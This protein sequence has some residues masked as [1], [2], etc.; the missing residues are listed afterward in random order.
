MAIAQP[1]KP[2]HHKAGHATDH[3]HPH[4]HPHPRHTGKK[5][6]RRRIILAVSLAAIGGFGLWLVNGS[7][8]DTLTPEQQLVEQMHLAASGGAVASAHSLGGRLSVVHSQNG[9]VVQADGLE[10][11]AC[12]SVGWR[13]ASGGIVTVNGQTP[14]RLSAAKL[15]ELCALPEDGLSTLTWVP[16]E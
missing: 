4:T 5:R 11:K 12:V 3:N 15:S 7:Q 2:A 13:L 1:G 10:S 16:R 8:P 6:G 9:L 14:A